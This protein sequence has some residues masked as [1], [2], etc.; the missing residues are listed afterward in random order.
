MPKTPAVKGA[1]GA[2]V[3]VLRHGPA[4]EADPLR[5]PDDDLRP[6][7]PEGREETRR[8]VEGLAHLAPP[9]GR[10]ATSGAE[11]A[12]ATA[13]LLQKALSHP[14]KLETWPELA[15]GSLPEPI[16]D[17]LGR[18]VRSEEA[19]YLVGHEPTLAEFVGLALVGDGLSVVHLTRGGAACLEFPLGVRPGGGRLAWLFTRNQLA[20]RRTRP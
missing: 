4:E 1:H 15:P 17:R 13:R 9:A 14:P 10:L 19:V 3:V 18:T 20:A 2:R 6:L 11:R 8:A 5:W 12:L 16:F 7:T